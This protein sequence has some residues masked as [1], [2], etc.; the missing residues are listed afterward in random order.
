MIVHAKC[1]PKEHLCFHPGLGTAQGVV[2]GICS[3][4]AAG[5]SCCNHSRLRGTA[6]LVS[7]D[8]L[9]SAMVMERDKPAQSPAQ[10]ALCKLLP[11]VEQGN[12]SDILRSSFSSTLSVPAHTLSCPWALARA[13]VSPV[14]LQCAE[15]CPSTQSMSHPNLGT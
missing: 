14:C 4:A 1:T 5:N 11:A 12:G 9:C 13:E 3:S 6:L 10:R 2:T 15:Q 7:A 8:L